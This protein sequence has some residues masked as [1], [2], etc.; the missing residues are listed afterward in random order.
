[1]RA[2]GRPILGAIS[3]LFFGL[4]LALDLLAFKVV[5]SDS[6]VLVILPIALLVLGIVLGLWAPF[7]RAKLQP[8]PVTED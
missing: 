5:E 1:M 6:P 7:G 8:A 3:G 4:F 2:H